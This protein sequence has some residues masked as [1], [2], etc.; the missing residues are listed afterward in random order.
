MIDRKEI[1][2]K[3]FN[4]DELIAINAIEFQS[5]LVELENREHDVKKL[6][7]EAR[8]SFSALEKLRVEIFLLEEELKRS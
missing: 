3:T 5:I 4:E 8:D 6:A 2:S 1:V 7:K